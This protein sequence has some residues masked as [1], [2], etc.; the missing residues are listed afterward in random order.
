MTNEILKEQMYNFPI[1]DGH[2]HAYKDHVADKIIRSFTDFYQMEPVSIGKGTI[3]DILDN[4]RKYQINYTVLA[5]FAPLKSIHAI[6]EWTLSIGKKYREFIPLIS[7]HPEMSPD[8]VGLL[9]QYIEKGAK[10]VKMHTGIQLF[11]PNDSRLK[12]LYQF[13]EKNKIPITFHCG[14]TSEVHINELADISHIYPVLESYQD[15][16]FILTHMAEGKLDDVYY[17]AEA[18]KNVYFDTSITVTGEH[19]IKR[20][21]D[22]YWEHDNNVANTFGDI[23]CDRITFGSDYPF[24]NPGSDIQR[25]MSLNLSMNEKRKILG[26]NVLKIYSITV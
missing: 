22:E 1:V 4:M 21:H 20:I 25:I 6:N 24:G 11:E 23:G 13:C 8:L 15:V 10:G 17:I 7:I 26:E 12:S 2:A 16:P 3:T 18:Y 14:E 19:C 9:E 5:N